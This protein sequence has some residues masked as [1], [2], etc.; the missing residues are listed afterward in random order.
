MLARLGWAVEKVR[1]VR[2]VERVA[3]R[4]QE[5]SEGSD[6]VKATGT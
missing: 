5:E 4:K 6:M 3:M 1:W 2:V